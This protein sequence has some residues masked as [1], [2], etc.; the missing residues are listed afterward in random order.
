M[1]TLVEFSNMKGVWIFFN[2]QITYDIVFNIFWC[3]CFIQYVKHV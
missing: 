3:V 1:V 2:V